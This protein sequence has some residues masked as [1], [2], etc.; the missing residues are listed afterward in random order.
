M[1]INTLQ[2]AKQAA[3]NGAYKGLNYQKWKR[4]TS[5]D[6]ENRCQ[7]N[8]PNGTHCGVGW[9][10]PKDKYDEGIEDKG[11][12]SLAEEIIPFLADPLENF[13]KKANNTDVGEF[14][15]F[16]V[17]I[18]ESHDE[19]CGGTLMKNKFEQIAKNYGLTIPK[20]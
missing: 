8:G 17:E 10:I 5:A 15:D 14:L 9:L 4:S 19:A 16:L 2:E 18:Q 12:C 3:F 7:Y 6:G 13:C 1:K 11:I 20:V